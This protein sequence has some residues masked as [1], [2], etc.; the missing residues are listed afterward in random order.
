MELDRTATPGVEMSRVCPLRGVGR[1][2]IDGYRLPPDL[3]DMH[4][5]CF[6]CPAMHCGCECGLGVGYI[7]FFLLCRSVQRQQGAQLVSWSWQPIAGTKYQGFNFRVAHTSL[8]KRMRNECSQ[9]SAL[10]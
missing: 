5:I 6:L 1:R 8:V 3:V 7:E 4:L 2:D 10:L 9:V